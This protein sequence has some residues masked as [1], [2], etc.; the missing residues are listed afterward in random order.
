MGNAVS[1]RMKKVRS[2]NDEWAEPFMVGEIV[3]IKG[4]SLK[5]VKIKK[6]RQEIHLS[7]HKPVEKPSKPVPIEVEEPEGITPLTP[8]EEAE[9]D[10]HA[11]EEDETFEEE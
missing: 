7:F 9:Y 3:E 6:L 11:N 5:I 10:W 1:E 4:V 8:E 2:R